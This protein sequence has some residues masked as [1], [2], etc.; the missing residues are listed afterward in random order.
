M[1]KAIDLAKYIVNKCTVE[2]HPVS[3]L[4]LQKILYYIQREY[5][6]KDDWAFSDSIEAW[7]FGP[8][9]PNVYYRFAA[10]GA[11][12]IEMKYS[13]V[14]IEKKDIDI[15]DP[16]IEEKRLLKPWVLVEETH[17]PGEAWYKTYKNGE[18]YRAVITNELIRE[19][20]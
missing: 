2:Q 17:R 12:P 13:D 7:Q 19:D 8:V 15:I 14:Q 11:M 5:T 16:I 20:V 18:G 6:K 3:N 10:S 4:Q 9:V 1:Y